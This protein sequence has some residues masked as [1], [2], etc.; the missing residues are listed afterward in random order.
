[1]PAIALNKNK[2]LLSGDKSYIG[3]PKN[4]HVVSGT[5]WEDFEVAADWTVANG[6]IAANI[7]QYKTGTQSIKATTNAGGTLTMT[8]TVNWDLSGSW[9]GLSF[10]IY[11]HNTNSDYSANYYMIQLANNTGVTNTM[12]HWCVIGT[13]SW[14]TGWHRIYIPKS[15]FA[16]QGS[17]TFSNPIIRIRFTVIGATGK[18]A[19]IS[20]D[21]L[22][23]GEKKIAA[24]IMR[25][26]DGYDT[27]YSTAFSYMKKYNI[28]GTV[29]TTT[30][31]IG[32]SVYM[33]WNQLLAM[34][35]ADWA[36]ANHT[37]L[38]LALVGATEAEQEEEINNAIIDLTD[39]GLS[40]CAKYFAYPG[41][42]A[43]PLWD[44][45]T[46]TAMSNLG[47]LTAHSSSEH[48]FSATATTGGYLPQI[49]PDEIWGNNLHILYV[50]INNLTTLAN[51]KLMVDL[52]ISSGIVLS[53][54]FH[55]VGYTGQMSLDNYQALIDYIYAKWK[56]GL[57][58][59]IT[60]DDYYKLSQGSVR[61][62][63]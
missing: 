42:G 52:A 39:H 15:Y 51:A 47:I 20:F 25:F 46:L 41:A 56:A 7:A 18:V 2:I 37:R 12:R 11:L 29:Y 62:S 10:W 44:A 50:T 8:K 36:I 32:G 9:D 59:P 61:I 3:L 38:H 5:L 53:L 16:V 4:L 28:R 35:N 17:G 13:S 48:E 55:R 21:D 14:A 6:T 43:D 60:I 19:E 49:L 40:R 57:I 45:N 1:M 24:V 63:R 31:F 34:S 33:T 27:N 26:D 23:V 54:L 58:Y 22:E 30:S